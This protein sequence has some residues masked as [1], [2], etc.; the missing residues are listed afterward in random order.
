MSR[1]RGPVTRLSRKL[2]VMLFTNGQSKQKA[3]SKKNYKP[4]EQGQKRF[5]QPSE[6]KKQLEEKQKARFMYGISEKQSRKYYQTANNSDEVTGVR[7]LQLL[8]QRLD[9][10]IYKAGIAATRPQA[11]QIVSHGLVSLNGRRVKTPSIQVKVGDNFE[12][13]E[14]KKSSK[15]FEEAKNGKQKTPKWLKADNKT[16]KGEVI[17]LPDKDDIEQVINHQLITEFYSK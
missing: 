16:L 9:N 2:G 1:Y 11:R 3:Y 4:G 13:V 6:Y 8:E 17:A 5:S 12:V 15:L 7:Y 10:V 14:K